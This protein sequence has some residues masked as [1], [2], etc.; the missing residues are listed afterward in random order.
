MNATV[1][2]GRP[3]PGPW[4]KSH[5]WGSLSRAGPTLTAAN[6]PLLLRMELWADSMSFPDRLVRLERHVSF[7]LHYHSENWVE[8]AL[9]ISGVLS[10]LWERRYCFT[11]PWALFVV[12]LTATRRCRIRFSWNCGFDMLHLEPPTGYKLR[13][14]P[15]KREAHDNIPN[16]TAVA[17]LEREV[18]GH[19]S[20]WTHICP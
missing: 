7:T 6:D 8:Q 13:G 20:K 1:C 14:A 18:A 12:P 17:R 9:H 5:R 10:Q 11:S 4:R 3:R 16:S 19:C 15:G 2:R